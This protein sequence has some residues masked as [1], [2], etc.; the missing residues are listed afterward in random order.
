MEQ[1]QLG[2][3]GLTVSALGFGCMSIANTYGPADESE[4]LRLLRRAMDLGINFF[5]TADVYGRGLAERVLGRAVAGRRDEVVVATKSGIVIQ[6]ET[7]RGVNGTP[8]YLRECCDV[9]LKRLGVD[10][11]D[12]YYLHRVDP[13][14]PIEDSVG[15]LAELVRLGKARHIGLSEASSATLRRAAAVH[16]IAALQ[17]EWSLWTRDIEAEIL[18]TAR[19]LGVGLVPFCPLGRGMITGAISDVDGLAAND[20]RRLD[21]RFV[22]ENFERH[23]GVALALED[24]SS[25]RGVSPAQLA[26]AWLLAQGLDVVPIPG[27]KRQTYLE[28]NASAAQIRLTAV[29]R[30]SLG[31]L[32][33]TD[34]SSVLAF[35]V[36]GAP[37]RGFDPSVKW[38]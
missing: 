3:S 1:R 29:E 15:A 26:L 34:L 36:P 8:A 22:G 10:C 12:L 5:D 30:D 37:A 18:P 14:V 27:T 28:M 23:R 25:E 4:S 38:A 11:I 7:G 9:S 21:P 35:Q 19:E 6:S 20:P 2:R 16:P 17:S 24:A 32:V 13:Q 33:P 31:A